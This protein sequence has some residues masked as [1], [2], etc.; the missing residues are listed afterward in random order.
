MLV[1]KTTVDMDRARQSGSKMSLERPNLFCCG[2][3]LARITNATNATQIYISNEK[4]LYLLENIKR[5]VPRTKLSNVKISERDH[6]P[7]TADLLT[8]T[9]TFYHFPYR[10]V[11]LFRNATKRDPRYW[12]KWG[13]ARCSRGGW[14][15][16]D[17]RSAWARGRHLRSF[18][19]SSYNSP[20][21]F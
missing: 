7:T 2:F 13:G 19:M 10:I 12:S 9:K 17:R 18:H 21:E 4:I 6:N 16:R 1:I 15:P 5:E 8:K 11:I 3:L 20:F 14:F